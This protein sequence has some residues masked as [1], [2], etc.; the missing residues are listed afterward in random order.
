MAT[1][2]DKLYF[3]AKNSNKSF[4][5]LLYNQIETLDLSSKKI[6]N[7]RI[8]KSSTVF[9]INILSELLNRLCD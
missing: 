4:A 9:F 7:G 3:Y 6:K 2:V 5:T 1:K 8:Y